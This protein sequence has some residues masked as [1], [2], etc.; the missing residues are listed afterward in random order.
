MNR[1]ILL[2]CTLGLLSGCAELQQ[3]HNEQVARD[4]QAGFAHQRGLRDSAMGTAQDSNWFNAFCPVQQRTVAV[5]SYLQGYQAGLAGRKPAPPPRPQVQPPQVLRPQV[6]PP[7]AIVVPDY[8][9]IAGRVV[10]PPGAIVVPDYNEIAGRVVTPPGAIVVPDY[11]EI[12]GRVV[13]LPGA[14]VVPDYNEIAGQV[15][16]PPEQPQVVPE[17][18]WPSPTL[19]SAQPLLL[20]EP[21]VLLEQ[22]ETLAVEVDDWS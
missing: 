9:E 14:I 5:Q 12:A 17:A 6:T 19:E 2:G 21:Q 8:N 13:T 1:A 22:P 10:T 15:I 7:G 3:I 18:E 11:N 4:C 16:A 20:P